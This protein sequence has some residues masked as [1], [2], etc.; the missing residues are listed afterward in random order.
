MQIKSF[1]MQILQILECNMQICMQYI[2]DMQIIQIFTLC[3]SYK[4]T[5][6]IYM[7]LFYC[8]I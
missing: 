4:F 7:T 5:I 6:T 2:C 8:K 3:N 1:K